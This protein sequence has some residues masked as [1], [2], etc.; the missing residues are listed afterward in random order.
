[1]AGVS[2]GMSSPWRRHGASEELK[3]ASFPHTEDRPGH[4]ISPQVTRFTA[5]MRKSPIIP[6]GRLPT[7]SGTW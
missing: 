5:Q 4:Q 2:E 7:T 6:V 1:M 3:V